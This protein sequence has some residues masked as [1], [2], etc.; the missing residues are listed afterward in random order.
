M[1]DRT[2][3]K[4]GVLELCLAPNDKA[5]RYPLLLTMQRAIESFVAIV[6]LVI[7]A[8]VVL[9]MLAVIIIQTNH[10]ILWEKPED[11]PRW[12][13]FF[14]REEAYYLIKRAFDFMVSLTVLILALPMMLL[15]AIA[16]R[17][18]SPGPIIFKQERV[19]ARRRY[20]N[21][22]WV[23]ETQTFTIYKFRTMKHNAD[24]SVH[25]AYI[26]KLINGSLSTEADSTET[27]LKLTF[28]AAD[29][30]EERIKVYTGNAKDLLEMKKANTD[31]A[32]KKDDKLYKMTNDDRITRIGGFLRTSSL[33]ELPQL[34]NVLKGDMSLVGPRPAL[35][36]EVK[37]YKDWH[38]RRL[39]A[40]PGVTG[41]W[42]V[43][44]RSQVTFD[45]MV[46]LDIEYVD[47]QSLEMDFWI[48]LK[49]PAAVISRRGAK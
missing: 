19:G 3:N 42:Q 14:S 26:D 39:E 15:T 41:L 29:A 35:P 21:G 7:I 27:G 17:L 16:V 11:R 44:A 46:K 10:N 31:V 8:P 34:F 45:E 47:N 36:Y 5:I 24:E 28:A 13:R 40:I 22:K 2:I 38:H 1:K 18:D 20:V 32:T 37:R 33:D 30:T 23:W 12:L 43:T 4:E 9:P 6:M 48:L 25:E 49:T